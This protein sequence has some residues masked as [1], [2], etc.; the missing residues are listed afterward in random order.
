MVKASKSVR[1][2]VISDTHGYLDPQVLAEFAGV[3]HIIHAGDIMDP[4]TLEALGGMRRSPPSPATWTTA[5]SAS[6]RARS[7]ARSAGCA[8]WSATSASA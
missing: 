3:D 7:R 8:S 1:I 5:S 6:C 2:G 4:A